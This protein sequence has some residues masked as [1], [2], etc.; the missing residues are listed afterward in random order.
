MAVGESMCR[1]V[2]SANVD[3]V[4][5][6]ESAPIAESMKTEEGAAD[7]AEGSDGQQPVA[8]ADLGA[9]RRSQEP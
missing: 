2:A 8:G 3:G 7:E 1:S 6:A 9:C 5:I 4:H